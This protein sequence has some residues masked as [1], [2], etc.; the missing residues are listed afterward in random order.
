MKKELTVCLIAS[1]LN[2]P[3]SASMFGEET[4]VLIEIATTTA[5]Q[6]NELEKLVS[7]AEKYTKQMQKYNELFQDQYFRAERILFVAESLA[8]KKEAANLGELNWAI[9]E[10]KYS[11]SELK[12][13][14]NEYKDIK[15]NE[16][17]TK[18]Q[19]KAQKRINEKKS[20]LAIHQIKNS[21]SAK[22]TGRATQL[23][24]RNTALIYE[25][26]IEM[27]NTQLEILEKM[28]T[29]NRLLAEQ[30]EAER[31]KQIQKEKSYGVIKK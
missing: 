1:I 14:M 4:A 31:F 28:S 18:Y 3:V 9:R 30:L 7:N 15:N 23:T 21:A 2:R 29:S 26:N 16:D 5:T 27:H 19:V 20:K 24:A 25:Q 13:L 17:K 10:L 8:A 6:L 22:T 11:M 12:S